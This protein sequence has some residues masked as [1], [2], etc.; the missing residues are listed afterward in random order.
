MRTV[1]IVDFEAGE[2]AGTLH[3]DGTLVV[4]G[5]STLAVPVSLYRQS[6]RVRGAF[7]RVPTDA[8]STVPGTSSGC[9]PSRAATVARHAPFSS[10]S[11]RTAP[12]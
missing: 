10:G 7:A 8:V 11:G 12:S 1:A 6:L 9:R 3:T 5:L 2:A 4:R